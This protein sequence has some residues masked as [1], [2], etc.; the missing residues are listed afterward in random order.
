MSAELPGAPRSPYS[1]VH[2]RAGGYVE[3]L[4][5]DRGGARGGEEQESVGD[6]RRV[7]YLAQGGSAGEGGARL[8]QGDGFRAGV[9]REH[10]VETLV[11]DRP[12]RHEVDADTRGPVSVASVRV[13]PIRA[14]LLAAYGVRPWSGR[15]PRRAPSAA[16]WPLTTD[17]VDRSGP[18][19]PCRRSLRLR[20][21]VARSLFRARGQHH[22]RFRTPERG[23]DRPSQHRDRAGHDH[24]LTGERHVSHPRTPSIGL[25]SRK[26]ARPARAL[27]AARRRCHG[28]RLG[29]TV[30]LRR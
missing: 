18:R 26:L 3:V 29:R 17:P 8:F 25:S 11:A 19:G 9:L 20:G 23:G 30:R 1:A 7:D 16:G 15:R 12:R 6:V 24:V 28:R 21:D 10:P 27:R 22:V 2:D 14:V 5:D 13:R 4:A